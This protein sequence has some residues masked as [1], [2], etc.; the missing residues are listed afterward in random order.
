MPKPIQ[1]SI[2]FN[3]VDKNLLKNGRYLNLVAWPTRNGPDQYGNTHLV[4]QDV[5]RDQRGS[6]EG[7]ILGNLKMPSDDERRPEPPRQRPAPRRDPDLDNA[8]DYRF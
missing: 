8:S 4:K 2:D 6:V 5:P 3:K 7:A 1:I